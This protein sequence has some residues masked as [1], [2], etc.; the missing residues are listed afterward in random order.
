MEEGRR[1]AG[2]RKKESKV[3][4]G[5][6]E[7]FLFLPPSFLLSF[8][9]PSFFWKEGERK[10]SNKKNEERRGTGERKEKGRKR[11]REKEKEEGE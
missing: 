11:R 2:R 1:K 4:R 8:S 6:R 5:R 10:E 9:W 3:G 7:E